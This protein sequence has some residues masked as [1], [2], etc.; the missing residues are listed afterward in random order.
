ML[1]VILER[2]CAR[3]RAVCSRVGREERRG[4]S[5]IEK[6]VSQRESHTVP[7]PTLSPKADGA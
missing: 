5:I 3:A 6:Q 4:L 2:Y 7:L 1:Y